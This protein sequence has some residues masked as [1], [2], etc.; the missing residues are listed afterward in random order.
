MKVQRF[1]T[2]ILVLF[3]ILPVAAFAHVANPGPYK[4]QQ[5]NGA[6]IKATKH[7]GH[8]GSWYETMDGY[9]IRQAKNKYWYYVNRTS[10]GTV[11]NT[12]RLA[13]LRMNP[14][15]KVSRHI[16]PHILNTINTQSNSPGFDGSDLIKGAHKGNVLILLVAFQDQGFAFPGESIWASR[17]ASSNPDDRNIADYFDAAS[18]GLVSFDAA[19]EYDGIPHNGVVGPLVLN[20][21]HPNTGGFITTNFTD[22][23]EE[24]FAEAIEQAD[25]FVN[26]AQYDLNEDSILAPSELSIILVLAGHQ[27]Q[28]STQSPSVNAHANR[29]GITPVETDDIATNGYE[30]VIPSRYAMIGERS[31]NLNTPTLND[32]IPTTLGTFVHELGHLALNLPDLYDTDGEV[33]GDSGGIGAYGVMGAGAWGQD[34]DVDLHAGETPTLP[35]AWTQY[36]LGWVKASANFSP[37][38]GTIGKPSSNGL[39]ATGERYGTLGKPT[40]GWAHVAQGQNTGLLKCSAKE[41]F[42]VQYRTA[43]GYDRGLNAVNDFFGG[44]YQGAVIYHVDETNPDNSDADNM[45]VKIETANNS[46][47]VNLPAD[48]NQLW[49]LFNATEF[50]EFTLPSSISNA[51]EASGVSISVG[52][53]GTNKIGAEVIE[54]DIDS[55]CDH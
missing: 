43:I 29:Y 24:I 27:N 48:Y 21:D 18:Y 15:W 51:G 23:H 39:I 3:L 4:L 50:N 45:L 34:S 53:S 14:R 52:A 28:G 6:Q 26:F 9:T 22:V 13:H 25:D 16:N 35:S 30:I 47:V 46:G 17:I 11:I 5:P 7:G 2:R 55:I 19:L 54:L 36:K 10:K 44:E 20:R 1:I 41:Y 32:S 49:N 8:A 33:D 31:D 40:I 38:P 37:F 42:L 12:R